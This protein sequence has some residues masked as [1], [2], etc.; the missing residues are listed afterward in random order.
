M[1]RLL[2]WHLLWPQGKSSLGFSIKAPAGSA[3]GPQLGSNGNDPMEETVLT[4][5]WSFLTCFPVHTCPPTC[6]LFPVSLWVVKRLLWFSALFLDVLEKTVEGEA[7]ALTQAKTLYKSCTNER[8]S[9]GL[10][11]S[12]AFSTFL[13]LLV[14]SAGV[15]VTLVVI[16]CFK[17]M[18]LLKS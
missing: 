8:K 15:N 4:R 6:C 13:S 7:A 11:P 12:L 1:S 3:S 17:V 5:R 16:S 9:A 18:K 2:S 14:I 10:A